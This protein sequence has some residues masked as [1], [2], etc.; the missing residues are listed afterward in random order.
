[1]AEA[2]RH[3]GHQLLGFSYETS[4]FPSSVLVH[5]GLGRIPP[6]VCPKVPAVES[7]GTYS[8]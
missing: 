1:V 4:Y 6:S 8:A 2:K 7:S 3:A 5:T